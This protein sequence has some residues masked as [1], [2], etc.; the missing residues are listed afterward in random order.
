MNDDQANSQK[1]SRWEHWEKRI[2]A[3]PAEDYGFATIVGVIAGIV[4]LFGWAV[5]L[6]NWDKVSIHQWTEFIYIYFAVLILAT[7]LNKKRMGSSWSNQHWFEKLTTLLARSI[8]GLSLAAIIFDNAV[9]I[10]F[11]GVEKWLHQ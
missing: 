8:I 3:L 6:G 10:Y 1:S 5:L 2:A 7:V 9:T 11:E 4:T